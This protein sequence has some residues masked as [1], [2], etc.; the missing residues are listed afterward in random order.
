VVDGVIWP[1]QGGGGAWADPFSYAH[2]AGSSPNGMRGVAWG[3]CLV[4][5]TTDNELYSFH[6]GGVNLLFA[7]GS[8]H[9][10][11]ETIDK[12]IIVYL[13]CRADGSIISA[14]QY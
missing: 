6:P 3:T 10:I 4:N 13:I 12:K 11:K 9:W 8:V 2:L 7:D 5:C 1:C 14:D